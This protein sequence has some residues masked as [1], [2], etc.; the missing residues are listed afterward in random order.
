MGAFHSTKIVEISG[1]KS[2][3]TGKVP[4]NF[5]E[6]LEIRFVLVLVSGNLKILKI[7]E[8]SV[9]SVISFG[10]SLLDV[11]KPHVTNKMAVCDK[12]YQCVACG[13]LSTILDTFIHAVLLQIVTVSLKIDDP[14]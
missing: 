1:L 14:V 3:G 5:F 13:L 10:F 4:G 11:L 9:P 2:N 6:K 7:P 8:F 12:L